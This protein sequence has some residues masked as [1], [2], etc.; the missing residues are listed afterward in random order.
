[1]Q[2]YNR[3]SFLQV[4]FANK[5]KEIFNWLNSNILKIGSEAKKEELSFF[6]T[7]KSAIPKFRD[8]QSPQDFI[9]I[10]RSFNHER[11]IYYNCIMFPFYYIVF[12]VV[13]TTGHI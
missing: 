13:E 11:R 12:P 5:I 7:A 9:N 8:T 10:A 2:K 6:L 1:M 4:F 3:I